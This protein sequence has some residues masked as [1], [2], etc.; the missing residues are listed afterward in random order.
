[1][2]RVLSKE[3]TVVEFLKTSERILNKSDFSYSRFFIYIIYGVKVSF[4]PC[5]DFVFLKNLIFQKMRTDSYGSDQE[6]G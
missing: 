1:M 2:I 3:Q 5:V 6:K 4:I